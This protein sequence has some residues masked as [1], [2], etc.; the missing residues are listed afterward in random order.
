MFNIVGQGKSITTYL[1][2]Y[3]NIKIVKNNKLI[4]I[5]KNDDNANASENADQLEPS[6]IIASGNKEGTATEEKFCRLL[7]N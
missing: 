2:E 4:R 1:S 6:Y 3:V 7:N 5:I